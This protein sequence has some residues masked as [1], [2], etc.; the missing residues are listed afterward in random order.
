MGWREGQVSKPSFNS[1]HTYCEALVCVLGYTANSAKT[2]ANI[3]CT[4]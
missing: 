4:L 2:K 3:L 1:T